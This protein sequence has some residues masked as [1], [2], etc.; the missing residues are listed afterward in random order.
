MCRSFLLNYCVYTTAKS[1]CQ[2]QYRALLCRPQKK[3]A[4]SI[5][6]FIRLL[7]QFRLWFCLRRQFTLANS[8]SSKSECRMVA[9]LALTHRPISRCVSSWYHHGTILT[10]KLKCCIVQQ[11]AFAA[12][13]VCEAVVHYW[14]PPLNEDTLAIRNTDSVFSTVYCRPNGRKSLGTRQT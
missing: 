7:L 2:T 8:S 14:L 5:Y 9:S 4:H 3:C 13:G 12:L 1:L 10:A 11:T 6:C